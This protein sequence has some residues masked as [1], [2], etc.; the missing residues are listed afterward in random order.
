MLHKIASGDVF[1][2]HKIRQLLKQFDEASV[3]RQQRCMSLVRVFST[4]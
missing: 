1:S 2:V 4:M 3:N